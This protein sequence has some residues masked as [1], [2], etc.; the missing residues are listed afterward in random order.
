MWVSL[1]GVP[2]MKLK[3]AKNHST[4]ELIESTIAMLAQCSHMVTVKAARG[5]GADLPAFFAAKSRRGAPKLSPQLPIWS[6]LQLK[7]QRPE[8]SPL[9][10]QYLKWLPLASPHDGYV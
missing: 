3:S 2:T 7:C 5:S 1:V 10:N 4:N 8:L 9:L 6:D